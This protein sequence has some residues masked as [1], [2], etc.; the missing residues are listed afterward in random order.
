[1]FPDLAG[2]SLFYV[3]KGFVVPTTR[4]GKTF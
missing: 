3:L 1:M 2:F 4:A